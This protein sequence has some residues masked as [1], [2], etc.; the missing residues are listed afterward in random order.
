MVQEE[1]QHED[2]HGQNNLQLC[3]QYV[4][5]AVIHY[6][7]DVGDRDT[8]EEV[9]DDQSEHEDEEDD[10]QMGCQRKLREDFLLANFCSIVGQGQFGGELK[11]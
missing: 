7:G 8:H 9:H 3:L 1:I 2:L 10:G 5:L 4:L 6:L 11:G